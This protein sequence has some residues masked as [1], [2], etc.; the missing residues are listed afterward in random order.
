[1]A[2]SGNGNSARH[3]SFAPPCCGSLWCR[4]LQ[5]RMHT[6]IPRVEGVDGVDGDVEMGTI[7]ILSLYRRDRGCA[8]PPT[9]ATPLVLRCAWSLQ[10]VS[11]KQYEKQLNLNL[12]A[13]RGGD[14]VG[15]GFGGIVGT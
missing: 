12:L 4:A 2:N 6:C 7:I 14:W 5:N 13:Y 8:P 11:S 3:K 10:A 1:M 15:R 9:P